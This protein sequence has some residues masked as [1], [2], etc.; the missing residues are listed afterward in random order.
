MNDTDFS[1]LESGDLK[2]YSA[3]QASIRI[4]LAYAIFSALWILLS[5]QAV[6][7]LISDANTFAF[8]STIKGWFFVAVTS[9]FLAVMVRSHV[10]RLA[11]IA[12]QFRK[13]QRYLNNII[14]AVGD[15]V[16]VKDDQSRI[17]FAN[18]AFTELFGIAREDVLGKTLAEHVDPKERDHFLS[19]DR[20]VISD[21]RESSVEET[22]TLTGKS[23]RTI[24]T[25]KTRYTDE[26]GERFLVGV[27]HDITARKQAEQALQESEERFRHFFE[28]NTSVMLLIEP[29]SGAIVAA[30]RSALA[31]Y[32]YPSERILGASIDLLNTMAPQAIAQ[33]R[34]RALSEDRNY[35]N[36]QHRL[37]N[38]ELRD[39]EVYSTPIQQGGQSILI[40]IVHDITA[41]KQAED[42]IL[43]MAQHDGLT[44]LANRALF[45]DRLQRAIASAVRDQTGLA[46]MF[47]DLD[48]FKPVNDQ[49]GHAVGD[50]L[51]QEVAQRMRACVRDSDTLARIGGDEFVVLLRDV[52][53]A[54]EALA[55]AE[56]IRVSMEQAFVLAEHSLNISCCVGVALYPQHGED[57]LILSKH[58][59][60]AM[61]QAKVRGRNQVLMYHALLDQPSPMDAGSG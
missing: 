13:N 27:I 33:E 39:V 36:F 59:D 6:A 12:E 51:L 55:V 21:G 24:L 23:P 7:I 11:L 20:Q 38:G 28:K 25:K 42:H 45:N 5:D 34:Q 40:S 32:G 2:K 49:F 54:H 19:V 57:D 10:N 14:H 41:R 1:E 35:F 37:A 48:K 15:P 50:L 46:L 26:N 47:I 52:A 16:F 60:A 4:V 22:L 3:N 43:H 18:D 53:G 17:L 56:K 9:F 31:Y 58:A 8:V 30:N 61:Y 44:G 29:D